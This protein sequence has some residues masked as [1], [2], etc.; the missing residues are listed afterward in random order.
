MITEQDVLQALRQVV[1]PELH[2]DIVSLHMVRNLEV[3]DNSVRFQLALTTMACPLLDTL[4]EQAHRA[5]AALPGVKH[6]GVDV[7]EMP[8]EEV[9]RLYQAARNNGNGTAGAGSAPLVF[10]VDPSKPLVQSLARQLSPVKYLVGVTSGKG[11]V[12]KSTVTAMLA[13]S[14]RRLGYKVGVLDADITGA[15]IPKIFGL[16]MNIN[17]TPEGLIPRQTE[18]GIKV[19]SANLMLRNPDDPVAWRGSRIA[20]LITDLWRDVIWG[21]LDYLLID[22]PPGTSDAQLTV[23]MDLPINGVIMVTTPQELAGLIVRK[24]VRMS[25]DMKVP[26]LGIIENMSYFEC[27]ETGTRYELFGHS[28]VEEVTQLAGVPLL[29]RL[30][31]DTDLAGACDSGRIEGYRNPVMD[32]VAQ[33]VDRALEKLVQS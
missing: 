15:S 29:A 11:G 31:V 18:G 14:L 9:S 16:T 13:V 7:V 21:P 19:I 2:Q 26:L 28:H 33:S 6:V 8:Q 3:E 4:A 27:P 30:P 23:M 25:M 20:Q 5:V 12:G 1:D 10:S 32:G 24:A 22:F 17:A